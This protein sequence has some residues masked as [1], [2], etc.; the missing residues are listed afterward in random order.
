MQL[1]K[2]LKNKTG[3]VRTGRDNDSFMS[4]LFHQ[5]L[6]V[7]IVEFYNGRPIICRGIGFRSK[8]I[9]KNRFIAKYAF[10]CR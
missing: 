4:W 5:P 2:W 1:V 8:N 6:I 3:K 7:F 10:S 9:L